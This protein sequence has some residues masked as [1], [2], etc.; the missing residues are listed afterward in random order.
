MY[1]LA[2]DRYQKHPSGWYHGASLSALVKLAAAKQYVLIGCDSTGAN[3][4]LC[5]KTWRLENCLPYWLPTRFIPA[6]IDY[7]KRAKPSNLSDHKVYVAVEAVMRA[8]PI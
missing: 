8:L 7:A 2:F 6:L 3:A 5:V 1:D 4:F